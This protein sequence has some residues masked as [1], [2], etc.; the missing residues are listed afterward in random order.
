[1]KHQRYHLEVVDAL[2][3]IGNPALGERVRQ[4][5]GSQLT[6]LGISFP[7]LRKRVRQGFSFYSLSEHEVLDVWDALWSASPYGDVLFAALEYYAPVVRNQASLDHWQ[8]MRHWSARIDNWCHSDALCTLYS[9]FLERHSREV[10][11][12]IQGWNQAEGEWLRRI[13]LVSLIHYTGKNAVFL[14]WKQVEPMLANCVDDQR[15]HVQLAI[16]WVLREMGRVYPSEAGAF[17][18]AHAA[19]LTATAFARAIEKLSPQ[20]RARLRGLR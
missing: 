16:G 18:E 3:A 4:D 10:F 12:Q 20:E 19:P 1:M 5:R 14:P 11:P 7:T 17:L 15:R 2:M 8:V 13:S 9:R 6:H